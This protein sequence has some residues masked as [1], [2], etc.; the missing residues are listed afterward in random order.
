MFFG[1][2]RHPGRERVWCAP[3]YNSHINAFCC[4]WFLPQIRVL[5]WAVALT[6]SRSEVREPARAIPCRWACFQ[7]GKRRPPCSPPCACLH[8]LARTSK[9][10]SAELH[11]RYV[12][13]CIQYHVAGRWRGTEVAVKVIAYDR[14]ASR[15]LQVSGQG[16]GG[17]SCSMAL[18]KALAS[19]HRHDTFFTIVIHI[20]SAL[21]RSPGS[22][23]HR[24]WAW[25]V[26]GS[27]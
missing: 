11:N 7:V 10:D 26:V 27:R 24:N 14:G 17:L 22:R 21:P 16:Q 19:L 18:L 3:C 15:K 13:A 8:L 20:A 4:C 1:R 12:Y 9:Y 5:C 25:L 2:T 23:T 6:R